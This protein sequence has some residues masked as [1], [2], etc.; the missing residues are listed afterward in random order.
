M[1]KD[2][3]LVSYV[4]RSP[5]TYGRRSERIIYFTPHCVVGQTS[6]EGLGAWFERSTTQ[7]SSTYGIGKDGSI[8][9]YL[10]ESYHSWCTSSYFNDARAI[11]IECASDTY[12]PYA[13]YDVVYQSLINLAVDICK[14]LG[15]TKLIWFGDKNK[16]LAYK[17]KDD[18]MVI[19]VHRW[20]ANKS[21]PGD[22]LYSRLGNLAKEVTKRLQ[23]EKTNVVEPIATSAELYRVRKSWD[24]AKTQIGAFK[25]L[26]NAKS[27]VER[28]KGYKVYD[29]SGNQIYPEITLTTPQKTI[30]E[31]AKEV[32]A[33]KWGVG[34]VRKERLEKAG[35]NYTQ[36]QNRVNALL[37]IS[38]GATQ[39]S[40]TTSEIAKEVIAGQWGNG[41]TRIDRLKAAGYDPTTIQQL[42]NTKLG[43]T[44]KTNKQIAD[45]VLA[46]KWGNGT[47][48]KT[49][50]TAAGYDYNAIQAIV[51][52]KAT[53]PIAVGDMVTITASNYYTGPA[54]P[55][56][57]K[58]KKHEV[59]QISGDKVLL[60][61]PNGICSWVAKSGV[62]K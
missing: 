52:G 30:D 34:A 5:N 60:G 41:Q 58:S 35:Y 20:F 17:V 46:G 2:S 8:A 62:V 24:D 31:L 50:L 42:V 18:E 48:R 14:R 23:G 15:R 55:S 37:G 33:G 21:C 32:I 44:T 54:I 49:K 16:T 59:S 51:N 36:V 11:T 12:A 22:W 29:S 43:V 25:F 61:F 28:N 39:Q 4:R 10:P 3:T 13:M 45:E 53:K 19:T 27:H 6:V 40:K 47:D 9:Q 57:V 56:W 7:A 26:A 38:G 1:N